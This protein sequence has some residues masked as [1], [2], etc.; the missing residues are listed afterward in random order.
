MNIL[1]LNEIKII[2]NNYLN[3]LDTKKYDEEILIEEY[4]KYTDIFYKHNNLFKNYLYNIDNNIYINF[5]NKYNINNIDILFQSNVSN[6]KLIDKTSGGS[7]SFFI[8]C[9]YNNK[10]ALIKCFYNPLLDLKYKYSL[11]YEQLVNLKI[12]DFQKNEEIYN[13]Y[14]PKIY[15]TGY[16]K[17]ENLLNKDLQDELYNVISNNYNINIDNEI[18]INFFKVILKNLLSNNN[19]NLNDTSYK[20]RLFKK[21][22]H[23]QYINNSNIQVNEYFWINLL[24]FFL[25]VENK[26]IHITIMEDLNQY[27][28]KYDLCEY[29]SNNHYIMENNTVNFNDDLFL[30]LYQILYGIYLLNNKLDIIHNDVHVQNI[31]IIKNNDDNYI[32]FNDNY[33]ILNKYRCVI[34]DYNLSYI[35]NNIFNM[36]NLIFLNNGFK[37]C[38]I[39]K[40]FELYVLLLSIIYIGHIYKIDNVTYHLKEQNNMYIYNYNNYKILNRILFKYQQEFKDILLKNYLLYL[41]KD[42][43]VPKYM[44]CSNY[45]YNKNKCDYPMINYT[46]DDLLN[47]KYFIKILLKLKYLKPN[48]K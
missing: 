1:S 34:I 44:F 26:Y 40:T 10:P 38:L 16:V 46:A 4:N 39:N 32:E 30:I 37:K 36:S 43:I 15:E 5:F 3:F 11:F 13:N 45:K 6:I 24:L 47:N 41:N 22:Y 18:T 27:E 17:L 29:Y 9:L 21:Y 23:D 42:L 19:N 2:I 12:K 33:K 14:F 7:F 8:K 28:E 25:D 20:F 31:I 35:N 48:N